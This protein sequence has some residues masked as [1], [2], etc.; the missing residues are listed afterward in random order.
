MRDVVDRP[1]ECAAIRYT[2]SGEIFAAN[3]AVQ[4]ESVLHIDLNGQPVMSIVCSKGDLTDLVIGRL[5][6][7]GMISAAAD[8]TR[9]SVD[10]DSLRAE[11]RTGAAHQGDQTRRESRA[12]RIEP[13]VWT[14]EWILRMAEVF[15]EDKTSHAR[16]HGMHSAYLAIPDAVL[17]MRED[18]GRHNAFDKVVGWALSHDVDLSHCMLFTSGRVPTDMVTKALHARIPLLVSKAVATDKAVEIAQRSGLAL[19]CN[20]SPDAFDVMTAP[21]LPDASRGSLFNSRTNLH[22]P[23]LLA[24]A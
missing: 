20:A 6:T 16:T 22:A 1:V 11:V 21:S 5:Y 3:D 18:I 8:I 24:T 13:I 17:C 4:Q 2:R 10:G 14:P 12:E 19:I 15:A 7:D 23:S 9:L